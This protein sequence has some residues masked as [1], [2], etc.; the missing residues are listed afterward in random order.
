MSV[1][2]IG[3][4]IN[5]VTAWLFASGRKRDLNIR[6]AYLHMAADAAVSAGVVIAGFVISLTNWI[7]LDPLT[8]LI[9]VGVILWGT[10]SLF[11]DSLVM[12]LSAVPASIDPTVVQCFLAGQPGVTEVHDLH[13]WSMS[14]TDTALTAHLVMPSGHPGDQFMHDTAE[15]LH[16]RYGIAHATLQVELNHGVCT[17]A[18]RNVI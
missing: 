12:S 14:T 4:G 15:Q 7:W 9:I 17:L 11:R 1:A 18:P 8:S 5:A 6:G 13:I 2:A 10:W 3:I 16:D